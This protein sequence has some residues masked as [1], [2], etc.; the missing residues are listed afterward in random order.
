MTD[1]VIKLAIAAYAIG[2]IVTIG[3]AWSSVQAPGG[4]CFK[5]TDERANCA[6]STAPFAAVFW[7]MYWSVR[8]WS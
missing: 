1:H 6:V 8:L 2:Y 4:M 3:A 5:F 7:P